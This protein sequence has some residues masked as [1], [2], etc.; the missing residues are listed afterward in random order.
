MANYIERSKAVVIDYLAKAKQTQAKIE[1][2]R[3]IYLPESMEQE[4]KR[5]RG[6]LAKA[7]KAAEDQ[8]DGIY[9]EA[10]ESARSWATLDGSKLTPDA[11]LLKGEG[12]TPEQFDQL[13][14]RYQDNF[15]MLD[16]LRKYGERKNDDANQAAR[17]AGDFMAFAGKYNVRAIPAPDAKMK[18]WD[19]MRRRADYFLDV[20]DGRGMDQFAWSMAQSTG[21]AAFEAW[22]KAPEPPTKRDS[23]E[24]Q[25]TFREA[26]GYVKE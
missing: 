26:W 1:E 12:V 21:D 20:A 15:T 16:A 17:D 10:S 14:E 19:E 3:K 4:E 13:V 24:I 7:R 25:K 2:G 11:E 18:E 9:R 6:E 23:E 22:G 8:L 5:L